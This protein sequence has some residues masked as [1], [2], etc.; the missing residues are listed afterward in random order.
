MRI[1]SV[2]RLKAGNLFLKSIYASEREVKAMITRLRK[3]AACNNLMVVEF[4]EIGECPADEF[5]PTVF[6]KSNE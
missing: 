3:T 4:M 5:H 6:R 1:N 2:Y